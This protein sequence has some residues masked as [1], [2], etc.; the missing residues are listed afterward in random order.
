[1]PNSSILP[2]GKALGVN[3]C[4]YPGPVSLSPLSFDSLLMWCRWRLLFIATV[5]HTLY[6]KTR[7]CCGNCERSVHEQ[8]NERAMEDHEIRIAF[9]PQLTL[10]QA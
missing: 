4:I 6:D 8:H 3:I 10:I 2:W 5:P 9:S 1:M 7:T